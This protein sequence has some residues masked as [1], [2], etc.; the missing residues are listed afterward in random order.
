MK[1]LAIIGGAVVVLFIA[2]IVIQNMG[3]NEQLAN[4]TQYDT[5]DLRPSTIDQL[6]NPNYQ[7]IIMPGDLASKLESGEDAVVYFF[8]PECRHC[9]E[10]TPVLMDVAD[11]EDIEI[12]Q[13]NVLEYGD[14]AGPYRIESTP[15]I[16]VFENGQ[17]VRRIDGNRPEDTFR[18]FLT[19]QE[20]ES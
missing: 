11:Q 13:F 1:R 12:D 18:A 17:E 2:L 7:N 9:V 19:D 16:I 15:T 14:E 8:S 20:V 10:A 3:Q 4:N 6:D 5:D